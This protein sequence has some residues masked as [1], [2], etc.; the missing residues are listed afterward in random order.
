MCVLVRN[1]S[2]SG[3][4]AAEKS[5]FGL[6]SSHIAATAFR[7]LLEASTV[8]YYQFLMIKL[9]HVRNVL[10]YYFFNVLVFETRSLNVCAACD[11]AKKSIEPNV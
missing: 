6:I 3:P 10:H 9:T 5:K 8:K 2:E 1:A 7:M 4:H 11:T